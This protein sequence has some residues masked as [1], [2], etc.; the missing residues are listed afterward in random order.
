[1]SVLLGYAMRILKWIPANPLLGAQKIRRRGRQ[2]VGVRLPLSEPAIAR[3]RTANPYGSRARLVFELGLTTAFRREDLA[4]VPAE[5]VEA[6][7]IPLRTG[8]AGTL[9]VATVTEHLV[10]ALRAF[11]ARH[12]EHAT[13]FYALG[14]QKNG[15][16]IHKRTI[17]AEFE[18]AAKAAR[19]TKHERVHALRY[20]AATRLC[21]LGLHYDDIAEVTGHAMAA[22]ARH[23]CKRR[24]DARKRGEM[25]AAFGD[26]PY[27]PETSPDGAPAGGSREAIRGEEASTSAVLTCRGANATGGHTGQGAGVSSPRDPSARPAPAAVPATGKGKPS[28]RSRRASWTAPGPSEHV[29][30]VIPLLGRRAREG[31][32]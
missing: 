19:F 24:K 23:Y 2:E 17:S 6:G 32:G 12:P 15:H 4:R 26:A 5:D 21:E 10:H 25:L 27:R 16:P 28:P 9:V 18:A 11:R 7:E 22:M 20:T 13:A 3:F 31:P 30:R 14:A 8:K 29:R 1:M